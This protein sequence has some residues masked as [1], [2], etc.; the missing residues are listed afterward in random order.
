M[1]RDVNNFWRYLAHDPVNL[2]RTWES[3][4]EVMSPA[5]WIPLVK[6]MLYVAVSITNGCGYCIASHT[7]LRAQ[8]GHDR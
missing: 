7:R 2:A 5:R 3:L 6:E 1:S 8:G 4:K